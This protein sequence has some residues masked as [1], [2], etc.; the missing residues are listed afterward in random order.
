MKVS[1]KIRKALNGLSKAR[2]E[3]A[4]AVVKRYLAACRK[5][6]VIPDPMERVW[7]EAIE[8]VELVGRGNDEPD[9]KWPTRE[10]VRRYDV[11]VTPVDVR[12]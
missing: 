7:I 8:S 5:L 10:P 6:G 11:Y 2:R 3:Q 1:D 9:E 12:M 4:E